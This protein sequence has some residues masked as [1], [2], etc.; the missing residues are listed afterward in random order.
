MFYSL[1]FGI[2][3]SMFAV[4]A[5]TI[6]TITLFAGMTTRAEFTRYVEFGREMRE[7]RMLQAVLMWA[8]ENEET[9]D[10]MR[11][12]LDN[13]ESGGRTVVRGTN[14]RF[15]PVGTVGMLESLPPQSS[16][17]QIDS[18]AMRFEIAPDG[19]ALV[20]EGDVV[21]GNLIVDP[22]TELELAPAQNDFLETVSWTL[23]LAAI[24]AGV[25]AIALTV[26]LSRRILHPVAALTLAARSMES[27]DFSQR[28]VVNA[29]GEIA[30]LANAFNAM[31][32]TLKRNEDLRRNMVSD[33]AHELRTPLTNIRGYL[34]ALHDGVLTPES[35]VI[36][37]LYEEAMMLNG[38]IK[39]LQELALA[40]AGQLQLEIQEVSLEDTIVQSVGALQPR[41]SSKDIAMIVDFK[42]NLP[43]L[44]ADERRIAQILGNLISNAITH[45]NVGGK[46]RIS[47]EVHRDEVEISVSDT[48]EGIDNEHLP[49]IFERFYRA[50]PSRSRAT[51][52][53]G[54][55][56]AIVKQLVEA[57]GGYVRV[58]S[59]YGKGS[60]FSFAV[61]LRKK[62][63]TT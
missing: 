31:A 63:S 43:I 46:I 55:G 38:L 47:G 58:E 49:Y 60:T 1:R 59:I 26:I 56:L 6:F 14:F 17:Q 40:E 25:A 29:E 11:L 24:M 21:K 5:V 33:I 9:P 36:D 53:A 50:D 48:G 15:Y 45:T 54:L 18:D 44:H 23:V 51:G 27:G 57:H 34:E 8:D 61:P 62:R 13:L 52:G 20:Y 19:S 2:L 16:Q 4:A 30:E 35:C 7:E 22:I 32:A 28:V 37:L 12:A 39:D 41:A 3:M 10:F 42:Q